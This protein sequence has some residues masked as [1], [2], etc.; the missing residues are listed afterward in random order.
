MFVFS[1]LKWNNVSKGN[2]I[3]KFAGGFS[4]HH[5]LHD[6]DIANGNGRKFTLSPLPLRANHLRE[7]WRSQRLTCVTWKWLPVTCSSHCGKYLLDVLQGLIYYRLKMH[8]QSQKILGFLK[9]QT[10]CARTTCWI[11][12]QHWSLLD[13]NEKH[14][15]TVLHELSPGTQSVAPVFFTVWVRGSLRVSNFAFN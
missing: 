1:P 14:H 15:V 11:L 2:S 4:C 12:E 8:P 13:S 5:F 3:L 9:L 7:G 6:C 10:I